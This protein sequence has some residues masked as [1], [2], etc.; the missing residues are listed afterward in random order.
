[1]SE[2]KCDDCKVKKC[3]TRRVLKKYNDRMLL[4]IIHETCNE[5]EKEE[6]E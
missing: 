1:M 5:Y 3:E 6:K 4:S 2:F